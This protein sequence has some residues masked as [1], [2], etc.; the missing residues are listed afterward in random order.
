MP[1]KTN[2]FKLLIFIICSIWWPVSTPT[3]RRLRQKVCEFKASLSYISQCPVRLGYS[4]RFCLKGKKT[5][6][7][8]LP[9]LVPLASLFIHLH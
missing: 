1:L 8:K 6:L 4:M 5:S 3:L 7:C 9:G 2:Y